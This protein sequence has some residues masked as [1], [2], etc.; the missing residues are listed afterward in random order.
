MPCAI[1]VAA[2]DMHM[3]Y[4]SPESSIQFDIVGESEI[5]TGETLFIGIGLVVDFISV[6][7]F[8]YIASRIHLLCQIREA[9]CAM[10]GVAAIIT[11]NNPASKRRVARER[12]SVVFIRIND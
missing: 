6:F 2:E 11:K 1:E 12:S 8:Q 7:N 3:S 4:R 9:A 10:K 5:I